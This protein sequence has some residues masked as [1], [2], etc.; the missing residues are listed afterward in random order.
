MQ[1]TRF[2]DLRSPYQIGQ[3]WKT[4]DWAKMLGIEVKRIFSPVDPYGEEI[5]D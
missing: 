3:F 5:W 2:Y 4:R 1:Q